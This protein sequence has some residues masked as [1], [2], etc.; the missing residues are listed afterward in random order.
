MAESLPWLL[1]YRVHGRWVSSNETKINFVNMMEK[2]DLNK[3]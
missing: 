2:L 3:P 1:D